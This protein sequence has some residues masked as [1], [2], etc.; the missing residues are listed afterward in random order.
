MGTATGALG[1]YD[2]A[3]TA[4][5]AAPTI[6]SAGKLTVNGPV[7]F[8]NA[9]NSTM[10]FQV[11]NASSTNV[12]AVDT[13]NTQV[14][15]GT[16]AASSTNCSGTLSGNGVCLSS[17]AIAYV[18]NARPTEQI[19][20]TAEYTGAVLDPTTGANNIGTMTSGIDKTGSGGYKYINYYNWTTTQATSQSYDI[21][22]Q[23][24]IPKDFSAWSSTTP[25]TILVNSST[26]TAGT[27]G[28]AVYDSTGTQV[29]K[30]GGTMVDITP[31]STNTWTAQTPTS[32]NINFSSG[33]FTASGTFSLDLRLT[34]PTSGNIKV[35]T[36]TLTYLRAY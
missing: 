35:G 7:L 31:S 2:T 3:Q 25:M 33:T 4:G 29:T 36:I 20:M 34:S 19:T 1:F 17:A 14:L 12:L 21:W 11:Q 13:I 18:G 32:A 24:P 30:T 15:I 23:I 27:I 22:I 28:V 10:A 9:S 6:T 26:T 16:A 5:L 8:Q